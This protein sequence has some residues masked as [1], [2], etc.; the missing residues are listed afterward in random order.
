[1]VQRYGVVWRTH[2]KRPDLLRDARRFRPSDL[3]RSK[4]V[5]K[6]GLSVVYVPHDADHRRSWREA[7]KRRLRY[8]CS[9]EIAVLIGETVAGGNRMGWD[10]M[11]RDGMG[12]DGMGRGG[13]ERVGMGQDG[14]EAQGTGR[15]GTILYGM[16]WD[17]MVGC[18]EMIRDGMGRV[19]WDG[20]E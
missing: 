20:L 2:R 13:M 7:V 1:M 10:G 8:H 19:R 11:G 16:G 15:I 17:G 5:E 9:T 6:S 4:R 18:D 3:G 12:W 14:G